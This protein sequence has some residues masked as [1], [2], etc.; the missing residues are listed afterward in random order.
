M[1]EHVNDPTPGD[2]NEPGRADANNPTPGDANDPGRADANNPTP[3]NANDPMRAAMTSKPP[4]DDRKRRRR[5]VLRRALLAV[6]GL[7][8][9][10]LVVLSVLWFRCGIHGCPDVDML[11]GYMPDQASVVLD[12]DGE[13]V[14]K[15]FVTRRV[16]VPVDSM[17]QHLLDAFVAIEDRR[18]WDHG[19]VD[20]R[21]VLG[22]LATNLKAGGIE[23]GSSTITMQL[24][25][26]VFPEQLPASQQTITR[27]LGEARV[28]RE[29]EDRYS[30]REIMELYLNQI[31]FGS[32]AYGIEAAAEE[33][34]GK[35][36]AQLDLAES[37]M[38]A[39]LPRAPS[40]LNPRADREAA[41]E[42]RAL[43]LERMADQGLI[44]GEERAEA[45]EAE[46][47]L[48]EG[49]LDAEEKA[50]Y[51][52][53]AV[54]RQLEDELG[55]ALY[56][57]GYTIHTTLDLDM[58]VAAEEELK[59][60]LRAIESG[61][62]GSFP[63]NTYAV[64]HSDT[65]RD[66]SEGTEYLQGAVVVMEAS[67]GDVLALVGGRDFDDSQFNRATQAKRQPGS[68]F[69]PFVY[70]AALSAGYP[71]SHRLLDRPLRYM[72]D[73]N[74]V[75]EPR[76]YDGTFRGVVTMRQALTQ[77]RNVP[78]VRLANEV[79][80]SRVLGTAEQLG[81][82]DLPSNPS[83]VLGTAEV[84]PVELT[85]AYAA[86]STLGSKPEPRFVTRVVDT[87]GTVVWSQQPNAQRVIDSG[88]AFILTTM[89]QD[90][91][92]RGTGTGVRA[93][94]FSGAAAGKTG[95]TQD[96]ADVWFVGYTP[97]LVGT[98]WI[99]FD[100]RQRILR[101]ATGGEI[102]APIWGRIM[103]RAGTGGGSWTPPAGVEQRTVDQMGSIVSEG[104]V[105]QGA[106][107]TEYFLSGTSAAGN[108]YSD[109][110]AYA[111]TFG[112]P[113]DEDWRYDPAELDTADGWWERLRARVLGDDDSVTRGRPTG[114][115]SVRPPVDPADP[116]R[117]TA[118]D[119]RRPQP[120]GEP[121]RRDTTPAPPDTS[122]AA[123]R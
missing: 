105:P 70:A 43:V 1:D 28:A 92:N 104:C 24:A 45:A 88:V 80:L 89:L 40:R 116:A 32:G 122:P 102:A 12:R 95:T 94:G 76:N 103:E 46:L 58:Q 21:R 78:T 2:A 57:Q 8:L 19:G 101:G 110:Y 20:W 52:V 109:S 113:G 87:D 26:N 81:L 10:G 56:T 86:F 36:A 42:G 47:V 63:H 93:V 68:A 49:R 17:P 123:R 59:E 18:F 84:T 118:T 30:K 34:F 33:Y 106:T 96:A 14:G 31:Y 51:F 38:L 53:E 48:N 79:G 73:N 35:S 111:D 85:A 54:R 37:A 11:R 55:S 66:R 29:I 74:T 6:G 117:D 44:T 98:V 121:V 15:L 108:C 7:F 41:L 65:T 60:S 61:R 100:E 71:P 75:W 107:Y 23:E 69:K 27:K 67:S 115:D 5:P 77:S 120:L 25:R 91:V 50:P 112:L 39:A 13:E 82:E 72:L 9:L 3:G 114:P 83:V 4:A 99:G 22:A 16:V 97:E 64:I 90:V 119:P 62:Y